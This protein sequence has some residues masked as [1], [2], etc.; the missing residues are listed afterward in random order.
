MTQDDLLIY[1]GNKFD[2]IVDKLIPENESAFKS[3]LKNHINPIRIIN[4]DSDITDVYRYM[5]DL[6]EKERTISG[7]LATDKN[8]VSKYKEWQKQVISLYLSDILD[9][10]INDNDINDK[11]E[12]IEFIS[13]SLEDMPDTISMK[14]DEITVIANAVRIVKRRKEK[15]IVKEKS[16][17]TI[18]YFEL[19]LEKVE[20]IYR[21]L[22]DN[23][24]IEP[25]A[26]FVES[27]KIGNKNKHIR[28]IW[29]KSERALF[30][31]L[32]LLNNKSMH[33]NNTSIALL[34]DNMFCRKGVQFKISTSLSN[35]SKISNNLTNDEFIKKKYL[36]LYDNI[37]EILEY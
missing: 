20:K 1:C 35:L 22:N 2:E 15:I 3:F 6:K 10:I 21:F 28:S 27:F 14:E 7:E 30:V 31:F 13:T 11:K 19:D 26:D 12:K 18:F 37:A 8:S 16:K 33:L 17:K 29:L 32:F 9:T 34:S 23:K 4:K 36:S 25:N 24:Y 5:N